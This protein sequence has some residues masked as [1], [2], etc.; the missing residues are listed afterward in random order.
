MSFAFTTPRSV[1][2]E[3]LLTRQTRVCRHGTFDVDIT[4]VPT[5]MPTEPRENLISTQTR[6][7]PNKTFNDTYF[8]ISVATATHVMPPPDTRPLDAIAG[9]P[10]RMYVR[11]PE[12]K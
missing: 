3:S 1:D 8:P 4:I 7:A 10:T 9:F 5:K 6:F 2:V 12:L 11:A